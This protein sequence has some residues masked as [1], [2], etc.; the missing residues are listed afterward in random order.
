MKADEALLGPE[1]NLFVVEKLAVKGAKKVE[2]EAILEKIS[3]KAGQSLTNYRLRSMIQ[4]IY[5]MGYFSQVKAE[6]ITKN[7]KQ[8][9]LFHVTERP[10]I[11]RVVFDGNDTFDDDELLE[12]IK[13]KQYDIFNL[14]QVKQ[15]I[16]VMEKAYQEKGHFLI[17]ITHEIRPFGKDGKE[18]VFR[19]QEGRKVRVKRITFLGNKALS[20][21]ELKDNLLIQEESFFSFLTG[22]GNFKELEFKASLER[23]AY[24][25][26]SRGYLQVNFGQPIVT[27]S[28]DRKWIYV[29]LKVAEG[30]K[31][32]VNSL[33]FEGD[34]IFPEEKLRDVTKLEPSDVYS[35]DTL[36]K[37]V[38][39][40]TE[41]Y[42]DEGH[43]FVNVLRNLKL[44]PG[45]HKVDVIYSFEKGPIAYFG[46]IDI[47]GNN[48]TRDKVIRRE[49]RIH[50]GMKFSGSKLRISRDNVTRLGYFEGGKVFFNTVSSPVK[51]DVLDVEISVE[52]RQTGELSLGAGYSTATKGFIQ[53]SIRQI[54]FRG[55][56][57]TLNFSLQLSDFQQNFN[58]GF[59]EPYFNDTRWTLGGEVFRN[60]S[61]FIRSF[62]FE[63]IG[64]SVRV[65][66]PIED[67]TRLFMTYK[68]EDTDVDNILD[69]TVEESL[70]DG[71]ASSVT[72]SVVHDK[73]NNIFE[74]TRGH[75]GSASLEFAGVG[76]DQGWLKGELDGRY[77][78]PIIGDLT[79]RFHLRLAQLF[80]T[81]DEC[82][83]GIERCVPRTER[84]S[85]GGAR[86]MRGY[87]IEDIGPIVQLPANDPET[88]RSNPQDVRFFNEGGLTSLLSTFELEYPLI[89]E[90]G[91]KWVLFYDAG[92]VWKYSWG[93]D[94][95]DGERDL[96]LRSNY[97]FGF[98]WFSQIGVLRFEFGYPTDPKDYE[99]SSQFH[100]DIG[101]IF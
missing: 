96:G 49:L 2:P 62:R 6:Q 8:V 55:L 32:Y 39:S 51:D 5:D 27:V 14:G 54:N 40:L 1:K 70:E 50:E 36:R 61:T 99:D 42:Q 44:V 66:H 71:V 24:V 82:G 20:D 69:P 21:A 76:G 100:F 98:R 35:E 56:G 17:K 19:I 91:L 81:K 22:S 63:K 45:E 41:L 83:V 16:I 38:Q 101:Q 72:L 48:K 9:L 7:G 10:V 52:E 43:A 92:N 15:D 18:I 37:D 68:Y 90:A 97:G 94:N 73:R 33:Y 59:T 84:F 31:F 85:M 26:K 47:K 80:E 57:Q 46:K 86:N 77:Y 13:T 53:G 23:L 28:E 58:L 11:G 3:F 60:Q 25:Y 79:F 64:S 87:N 4:T 67:Y 95:Q 75:F 30:P 89:K 29:T 88:G 34:L 78:R 93:R 65:G 74:T 12:K